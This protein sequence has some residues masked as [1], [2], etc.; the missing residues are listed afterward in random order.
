MAVHK[1]I[2]L[3]D[4]FC[5]VCRY[6]TVRRG[7][8]EGMWST[9]MRQGYP[10]R[11][12][13]D[14]S[15]ASTPTLPS[16]EAEI[17]GKLS[18]SAGRLGEGWAVRVGTHRYL[19]PE[20]GKAVR[21]RCTSAICRAIHYNMTTYLKGSHVNTP[22]LIFSYAS[23]LAYWAVTKASNP[24]LIIMYKGYFLCAF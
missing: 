21:L 18:Y 20:R 19:C 12:R 14:F 6:T 24:N 2:E 8:D 16:S 13:Y 3:G 1:H 11:R 7:R 4:L 15:L 5:A 9:V 17:K 22:V 23:Q 10:Q